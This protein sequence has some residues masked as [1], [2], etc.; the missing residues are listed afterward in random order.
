MLPEEPPVS[1]EESSEQICLN[2]G[3]IVPDTY[4]SACGQVHEPLDFAVKSLLR[5]WLKNKRH[6]FNVFLFTTRHLLTDPGNVLRDYWSG[7][8]KTYYNPFNYFV[9]LGSIM[10]FLMLKLGNYDPEIAAANMGSMYE[11]M[12]IEMNEGGAEGGMMAMK[13]IQGH[14]NFVLMLTVPFYAMALRFLFR[15]RGYKLGEMLILVLYSTALYL[16]FVMPLVPFL[17]YNNPFGSPIALVN[18]GILFSI[19]TWTIKHTLD[20]G[21][22]RSIINAVLMYVLAQALVIAFF[23]AATI[24]ALIV[25][26]L[27]AL[28]VK[29]FKG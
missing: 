3:E 28:V 23:L 5:R 13:W 9:L 12:G 20:I 1:V 15:K 11:Q 21:W 27:V 7:K 4:C 17:D 6:H 8:K 22:G 24:V 10:A 16:L 29:L 14:F 26:L 2:C 25:I 19:W 18:F